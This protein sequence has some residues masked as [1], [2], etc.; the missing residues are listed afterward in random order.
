MH[1]DGV[2]GASPVPVLS[3]GEGWL[4]AKGD[5]AGSPLLAARLDALAQLLHAQP[6]D[7]L[8]GSFIVRVK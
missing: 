8:L 3:E 7:C 4:P 1:F 5:Q 6:P 2:G